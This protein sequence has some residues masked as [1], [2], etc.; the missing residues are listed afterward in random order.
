MD[1]LHSWNPDTLT[2]CLLCGSGLESRGHLFFYCA[3][4]A[5]VWL[6]INRRLKFHTAPNSW[7]AILTW[8]PTAYNDRY[9]RLALLQDWQSVIYG[10]W[11]ER[12][13]YMHSGLTHSPEVVS[14]NAL[15]I[16]I[17]KCYVLCC[18]GS[19]LDFLLKQIWHPP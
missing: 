8:L 5:E 1:R 2:T 10:I 13:T 3:Y 12:N 16:V 19:A 6:L 14:R 4:L 7:N 11:F 9:V 17:N 15:R 18:L